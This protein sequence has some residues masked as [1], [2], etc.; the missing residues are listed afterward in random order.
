MSWLRRRWYLP[1]VVGFF[2]LMSW[3]LG[4]LVTQADPTQ[5]NA[6]D[7]AAARRV[8]A[9]PAG[10]ADVRE[11]LPPA[12]VV[13]GNGVVEPAAPETRLGA[14]APGRVARVLAVEGATVAA[15]APLVE[16]D[17]EVERAALAA[18][19][20]DVDAAAAQLA[21]A[22]RGSRSEDIRAALADADSAKARAELARGVADRLAAA[23]AG[24]GATA[25]EV[26]RA[27]RQAEIDAAAARAAEARRSA[28]VAGSRREDVQLARAQ[29]AAAEARRAQAQAA[30][31][32][33]TVR[34]PLAA[35][36]LQVKYRAGEYYQPGGEPLVVL[37]DLSALRIRMDVDERDLAKVAV[38][39]AATLRVSAE[40]DRRYQGRV[41]E[42]GL[43]MG[44]KN[45]RTDD[46]VERNDAKVL[47]VV[48]AVEAPAGLVVG[49]RVVC[50]LAAPARP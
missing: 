14:A 26:E 20:A 40:P 28:V 49:Q 34:A 19:A 38:G 36:V 9:P 16:F 6:A 15:G 7:V 45:L 11:P 37:G 27:R 8:V 47:E 4:R 5:P 31:E 12:G 44:R 24:G 2:A 21:R 1:M 32:R 39:Q 10:A 50:Y 30:L 23:G 41:V 43:R 33:L 35:T 48:I 46:P 18:A 22:V 42:V 29:L 13:A 17:Q 3:Q 25:D